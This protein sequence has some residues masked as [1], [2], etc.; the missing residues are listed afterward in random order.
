M[1]ALR[2][3]KKRIRAVKSTQQITRAMEMVAAARL[4]KAQAR[5]ESFRPYAQKMQEMLS[6]L[7][8]AS[9]TVEHP[10]F[11]DR[12]VKNSV[13]TLFTSDRGLCGSFNSSLFRRTN[14]WL[15]EHKN[16]NPA[17]ILIGKKAFDYYKRRDVRVIKS[18]RDFAGKF[19]LGKVR[20]ITNDLSG[21]F[22]S[23]EV[24]RINCL[25][26]AFISMGS[27][28]ITEM[29]FL[30][31]KSEFAAGEE[32]QAREYIFEPDPTR[33]YRQLLPNYALVLIQMALAES[34]ASEQGTRMLAMG[35]ATKNAGEMID[36]LT[37][38]R[39]KARQASI[40]SELLEIASGA[41]ALK[42]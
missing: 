34:L 4:R 33:I 29:Q 36:H 23:G 41:E 28:R 7:S 19:D 6:H 10:Y 8:E 1:L 32:T 39:N 26:T 17:L 40:T 18:Y 22:V 12:E 20:E 3:I 9:G 30:P 13:L 14:Q 2:D 15:K 35:L 27:F 5:I 42:G 24:D 25:Y 38:I 11:E 37:L 21:M 31:I 16:E